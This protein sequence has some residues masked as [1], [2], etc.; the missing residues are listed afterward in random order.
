MIKTAEALY[1]DGLIDCVVVVAPNGVYLNWSENELPKHAE[2]DYSTY[3]WI[4]GEKGR[5]ED[6]YST[7]A[8]VDKLPYL[9]FPSHI[10]IKQ[11]AIAMFKYLNTS[12]KRWLLIVDESHD[13]RNSCL[14]TKNLIVFARGAAYKRILTGTPMSKEPLNLFY[15]FQILK[16]GVLGDKNITAF[17]KKYAVYEYEK[18]KSGQYY[19][20]ITGYRDVDKLMEIV[21]PFSTVIIRE[22]TDRVIEEVRFE[23]TEEEKKIYRQILKTFNFDANGENHRLNVNATKRVKLQQVTSGFVIDEESKLVKLKK[24]SRLEAFKK[25]YYSEADKNIVVWAHFQEDVNMLKSFFNSISVTPVIFNGTSSNAEKEK[26]R[27]YLNK[28][29]KTEQGVII[30]HRVSA[31]AGIDMSRAD[32]MIEYSYTENVFASEQALARGSKIGRD[33][34]KVYRLTCGGLDDIIIKSLSKQ[35]NREKE[36]LSELMI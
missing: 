21:K 28:D 6:F 26:A 32:V 12:G 29:S 23:L 15:Q 19:P 13:F 25:L 3:R 10:M 11:D 35:A 9:L 14:K 4:S 8:V 1:L 34:I 20:Q 27:K 30:A 22:V 18:N 16:E 2:I 7:V 17:T 5:V 33:N 31:G 36:T 24:S